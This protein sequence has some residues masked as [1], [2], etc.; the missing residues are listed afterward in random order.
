MTNDT[1]K[2]MNDCCRPNPVSIVNKCYAWCEIPEFRVFTMSDG[3]VDT[4]F[5]DCYLRHPERDKNITSIMQIHL[6]INSGGRNG[7]SVKGLACALMAASLAPL[8]L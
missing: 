5:S 7:I 1:E 3:R 4:D 6:K 2:R 8:I